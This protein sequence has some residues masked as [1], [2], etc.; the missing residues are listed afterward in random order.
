MTYSAEKILPDSP[1][2]TSVSGPALSKQSP[3][4]IVGN[5]PVGMRVARELLERLPNTPLV[6]YGDEQYQPYNRVKLSSWLAGEIDWDALNE[7]LEIPQD[8]NVTQRFGYRIVS[9]HREDNYVTDDSGH[10]QN[11]SKLIL[12]TGS[13][14]HVPDI[15]GLELSGVYT[16]RNLDDTNRL[17]A[18]RARSHHTVVLGG[19]LLGL[20]SA[21]GM[22]LGNTRVTL[23]EH[24][25]RLLGH[26]LDE[27]GSALLQENV[28]QLGIETIVGD[29][30]I[31]IIGD[32]RVESVL[33]RSGQVIA[34]DTIIIATGIRPNIDLARQAGLRF[35]RGIQV[36]DR[37]RTSWPNIYAIGECA[38]HRERIYGFVAPGL[39]QAAVAGANIA[40][41]EN[42]Y[43][44]SV[45]ASR[46]KVVGTQ[47]FSMG[48]M[49]DQE[50]QHF[51]STFSY[52]DKENQ[53]YRKIL[54]HRYRLVGAIGIGDW[55]ETVRIQSAI[56]QPTFIWPWQLLRF[57]LTGDLWSDEIGQGVTT[58]PSNALVCQCMG[59]TRGS[60]T[61]AVKQ[62]AYSISS[63]SSATGAST[64]CGSCRPLVQDLLG[65]TAP[66]EPTPWHKTLLTFSVFSALVG[67]L[68][69]LSV[70]LPYSNTVQNAWHW[71]V[72]WRDGLFKQISGFS[73]L[74]LFAIGLLMSLRKRVRA[75]D[76][77]G[78]FDYWRLGHIALGV[79]VVMG[80]VAHTGFRMGSGINF[81]LMLTFSAM[82]IVGALS[83]GII[84]TEHRIGTAIATRIRRLS[85]FWHILL[86][87]P[88]PVLL[89]WHV[90]KGYWF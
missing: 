19:G 71:D 15:E 41:I 55:K 5:G 56:A 47:V 87:W 60:I 18:R 17:L 7:P 72:L 63:V 23:I 74:G 61:D 27:A 44:G 46:L 30:V 79:L 26:Q 21:R 80:L 77:L 3:C 29:A 34:C 11:Y 12:A 36:D 53:I 8:A 35:D 6:I 85:V 37:M 58:W 82:L 42:D 88:I 51:G 90:L 83:S 38:E 43:A 73:I 16:F 64:V 54:L 69:Y 68:F 49:G 25:D 4:V 70:Q 59:V 52:E 78:K 10:T 89:S 28:T 39:E 66:M 24:A 76:K 45:A 13:R 84:A 22:Q 32:Q 48:P 40:E 62:G 1:K 75:W 31:K 20:E 86:F 57:K 67:L 33:L 50:V 14:P 2:D 9:I 65:E 81:I